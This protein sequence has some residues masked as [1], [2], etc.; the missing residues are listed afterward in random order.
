VGRAAA[1]KRNIKNSRSGGWEKTAW[2]RRD[3]GR[4]KKKGVRSQSA[5]DQRLKMVQP[6]DGSFLGKV[7]KAK[8]HIRVDC[9]TAV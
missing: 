3:R 6:G 9:D 5:W 4:D 8:T 1:K 7:V 2:P